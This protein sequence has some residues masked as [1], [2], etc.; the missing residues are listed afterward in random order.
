[1]VEDLL[2]G[3]GDLAGVRSAAPSE[4]ACV[5]AIVQEEYGPHRE[6]LHVA[7]IPPPV[8][9]A[10]EVL[11]RVRATSVH[12]DVWHAVNGLPYVLRLMGSGLHA[13]RQPVPGTDLAG[14]VVRLGPGG[15]RF[16]PGERVFG[17]VTRA[18]QWSNAGTFAELAAVDEDLL[19]R[20]P[21]QLSFEEAAAVPTSALIALMN[22]RGQG[23]VRAGQRVLVNGAGGA[24]GVW[25]VQLAKVFGAE[26]TAVDAPAKLDRLR[27]LGADH[28]IDYT[29]EDFT[30]MGLRF[31]LVFDVVSQAR[32]SEVRRALEPDGTFVLIGHD[33]Y[34][35]SRHRLLGSLGRMLPLLAI[36]PVVRQIPGIRP[37][38]SR[39]ES[40]ATI[41]ELLVAGRLRPVVD[42][43]T[44]PLD[45]AVDAIDYLT[46]GAAK[47]R[48]VLTL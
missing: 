44:F 16:A 25:A 21:D 48:V 15:S 2:E 37:G 42:E 29:R 14:E 18:N 47:G 33:Q 27:D 23:R 28:V 9:G 20:I 13:P 1:V 43:R 11:V 26:V 22:L 12:A 6:V 3:R 46:T 36:S 19:A 32:F 30:R 40:W 24:V 35:R 41:V 5:R 38:P 31:D 4:E 8:P 17:A 10:G 7:E 39:A 34:G 45:Q